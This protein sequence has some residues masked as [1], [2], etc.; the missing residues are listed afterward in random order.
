MLTA[1][2]HRGVDYLG[3]PRLRDAQLWLDGQAR[4]EIAWLGRLGPAVR[5]RGRVVCS[6]ALASLLGPGAGRPLALPFGQPWRLGS[7]QLTLSPAGSGPGSSLLYVEDDHGRLLV[8]TAARL[9]LYSGGDGAEIPACDVIVV[10]AQDVDA[11]QSAPGALVAALAALRLRAG[12]AG[13]WVGTDDVGVALKVAQIALEH[14]PVRFEGGL[15]SLVRR[16]PAEWLARADRGGA[17]RRDLV[18]ICSARRLSQVPPTL[19]RL[20]VG[21]AAIDASCEHLPWP[22]RPGAAELDQIVRRSGARTVI[23]LGDGASALAQRLESRSLE[24]VALVGQRQLALW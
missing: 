7:S 4:G 23:A 6:E 16:M 5:R 18:H 24:V 14:G 1:T 15:A 21:D 8:A 12:S 17:R 19:A 22:W 3:A 20:H 10:D 11:A 13:G 2:S 9:D